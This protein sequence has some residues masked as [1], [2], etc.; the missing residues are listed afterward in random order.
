MT[1]GWR[2]ARASGREPAVVLDDDPTGVQTLAGIRVLLAWDPSRVHGCP[3]G[4]AVRPP[5]HEHP[6]AAQGARPAVRLRRGPRRTGRR[7]GRSHR[8]P[9]RQH[10]P[11]PPA[12]GVP[13]RSRCRRFLRWP[14]LLPAPALPSAGRVT[15]GGVHI[16]DRDG[17][18]TPL[19][20]TE[21]ARDGVFAYES[22]R[23]LSGRTNARAGCFSPAPGGSCTSL[24]FVPRP[25][26][27]TD[28]LLASRRHGR[29]RGVRAR[30]GDV[31][32][33]DQVA[34]G[35]RAAAAD[36]ASAI[37]RCAPMFAG[38]LAGTT[39]SAPVPPPAA[40]DDVLVVC[41][42]N[43]ASIDL[44]VSELA[45]LP[46]RI[47]RRGRRPRARRRRPI[48]PRSPGWRREVSRRLAANR[49]A[50]LMP[51]E[52]PV[53]TTTL[54]PGSASPPAWRGS[55]ATVR[56][57]PSSDRGEGRDHR[58]SDAARRR[59]SCGG[60]RRRPGRA[61]RLALERSLAR[62]QRA[63]LPRRAGERWRPRPARAAGRHRD[64]IRRV[65]TLVSRDPRGAARGPG[66]LKGRGPATT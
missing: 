14:V 52:R 11:R 45:R 23:L 25:A 22:A 5:D 1:V 31:E 24:R 42:S 65:L 13:R 21:Y 59:R 64:R 28:A 8:A 9:R 4:A 35:Y 29:P 20:E 57:S 32:D 58:G 55:W 34:A 53:V 12:R 15:V 54:M 61:G 39:A 7:P 46:P 43:V 47:A 66:R 63:G 2:G 36:G 30:R 6:G 40:R 41:G 19:Q 3:R 51:R 56:P 10:A 44:E 37:V 33:L 50:V 17:R 27:V 18:R 48:R 16:F 26:A 62:R 49:L 60:R 38:V